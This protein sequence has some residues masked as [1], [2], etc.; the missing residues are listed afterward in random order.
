MAN[1]PEAVTH[2]QLLRVLCK[3]AETLSKAAQDLCDRL[4]KQMEETRAR[5]AHA[6]PSLER[7]RKPSNRTR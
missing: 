5:L 6:P 7:R 1:G 3:Q 2:L 4:T